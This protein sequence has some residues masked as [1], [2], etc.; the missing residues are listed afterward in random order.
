MTT[1]NTIRFKA[2]CKELLPELQEMVFSLYLED[3]CGE[4]ISLNKIKSTTQE[5]LS[6]PEKGTIFLF[7]IGESIAGYAIVIYYW[8]NEYGGDIAF[9]DEFFVKLPWRKK[10]VGSSFIKYIANLKSRTFKA[11]QVEVTPRN[12]KAF[13]FYQSH[14][15]KPVLNK[16]LVKKLF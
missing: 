1:A 12:K 14:G 3:P 15:F 4:K 9:I 6:H 13:T 16:P 7:E 8:S 10:G 2:Y 5:L 11:I